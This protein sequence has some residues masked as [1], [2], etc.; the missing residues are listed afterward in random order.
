MTVLKVSAPRYWSSFTFN[1]ATRGTVTM[2]SPLLSPFGRII[3]FSALEWIDDPCDCVAQTSL[4]YESCSLAS[5]ALFLNS[6][7]VSFIELKTCV[8]LSP[9][10]L[11]ID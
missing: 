11:G 9:D 3:T 2:P 5:P 4:V 6:Y 1:G 7:S 10:A 8:I